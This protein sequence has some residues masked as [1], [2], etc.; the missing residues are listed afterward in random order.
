L[1]RKEGG[2][3]GEK[4]L[5]RAVQYLDR[6][7]PVRWESF[8]KLNGGG[9]PSSSGARSQNIRE[10]KVGGGKLGGSWGTR[11]GY[12]GGRVWRLLIVEGGKKEA[13]GQERGRLDRK[14]TWKRKKRGTL[15]KG[16]GEERLR[17]ISTD[18]AERG[19]TAMT[20]VGEGGFE[21]KR[22]PLGKRGSTL[23]PG[24]GAPG[25]Q[26]EGGDGHLIKTG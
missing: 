14:G 11:A 21:K 3:K 22:V 25:K 24:G 6:Y 2:A 15:L 23:H 17:G 20:R 16:R 19:Q 9:P 4:T 12:E 18:S 7:K 26:K 5:V 10:R 8:A 13:V 1:L